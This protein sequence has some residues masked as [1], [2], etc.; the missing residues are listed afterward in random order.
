MD[1]VSPIIQIM[2]SF[3]CFKMGLLNFFFLGLC[4]TPGKDSIDFDFHI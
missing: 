1:F 4:F 3:S 2:M